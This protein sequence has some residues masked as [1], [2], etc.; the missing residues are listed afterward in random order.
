MKK[1]T[2]ANNTAYFLQMLVLWMPHLRSFAS[3][4]HAAL[5]GFRGGLVGIKFSELFFFHTPVWWSYSLAWKNSLQSKMCGMQK[6]SDAQ[7]G[8]RERS[9]FYLPRA[10][11]SAWN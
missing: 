1:K 9:M 11:F 10:E 8:L 4:K 2:T 3:I 5:C 7:C 6:L